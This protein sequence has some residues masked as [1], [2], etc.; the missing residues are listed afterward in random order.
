MD[1]SRNEIDLMYLTN[2]LTMKKVNNIK[3]KKCLLKS[4]KDKYKKKILELINGFM[5]DEYIFEN[6]MK[7]ELKMMFDDFLLKTIR[8]Y[9]FQNKESKVQ[10]QYDKKKKKKSKCDK[11]NLSDIDITIMNKPK[12]PKKNLDTFIKKKK[13]KKKK[14]VI[15]PKKINFE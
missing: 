6:V 12:K 2:R 7:D 4:E 14:K 1:I 15:M 3:E 5:K 10:S 8:Y 13:V 11:I 9:K